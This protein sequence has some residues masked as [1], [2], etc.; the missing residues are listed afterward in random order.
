ME[1]K[2]KFD[3][4][5]F[6][7]IFAI[8]TFGL[9]MVYSA[10]RTGMT[11]DPFYFL[12]RQFFA[13]LL[14]I[15]VAFFVSIIGYR[16]ISNYSFFLYLFSLGLLL[17]VLIYGESK[18]GAQRWISLGSFQ[19]QPSEIAKIIIIIFLSSFFAEK[20]GEVEWRDVFISLAYLLPF[21]VLVFKQPDLGTALVLIAIY[22]VILL[23]A[24]GRLAHFL[25][26]F[27]LGIFSFLILW[28]GHFL[29]EYQIKRLLTFI[30]PE[31]DPL[32]SG[33]NIRQAQIAIGSGGLF[34]KGLFSGTQT[35]LR[36]IPVRHA[37]F[38]FAVIGEEL[39]FVGATLLLV[40]FF[41]LFYRVISL[42]MNSRDLLGTLICLGISGMWFFQ[43]V[44]NVGMNLG[45]MPVTGIPLP[46]VSY[47]GSA[48]ITNLI[49]VGL[50]LDVFKRRF[51]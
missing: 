6:F 25:A 31:Y 3:T 34:G 13:V 16:R 21:F 35:N 9:L 45:I 37:D 29:K 2:W 17:F 30:H 41:L 1:R 40:L 19:L 10:T 49:A 47:G 46:F 38:I 11:N 8:L 44:V 51:G 42:A 22:V 36:F 5:L 43:V 4:F 27:F 12:K 24:G 20:K 32:G 18:F 23:A 39:G 48:M 7:L 14:G 33:Y 26:L 28:K 50:V 15:G